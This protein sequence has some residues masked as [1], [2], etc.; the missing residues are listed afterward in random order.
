MNRPSANTNP[1]RPRLMVLL[2]LPCLLATGLV[3]PVPA[4][5]ATDRVTAAQVVVDWNRIAINALEVAQTPAPPAMRIGAIVQASVFDA[6][7]GVTH[8]FEP[9]HVTASAPPSTSVAASAAGAAHEALVLLL[10]AQQP[11]LDAA[12]AHTISQLGGEHHGGA[13]LARGLAWGAAVADQ[14]VSWRATDGISAV[15]PPYLPSP[16]PGRW[17]PAPP[18]FGT[19]AFRQFAIMTPF[20]MASPAQFLPPPPPALT[21]RRYA[22]DFAEVER[23]GQDTSTTRSAFDTVT[24]QFWQSDVGPVAFWDRVADDLI[25]RSHLSVTSAAR[26]LALANVA[27]ADGVISIW[28]AKNYYDTWR[29]LTAIRAADTDGN[30]ATLADPTWN[31]LLATP[32][33]QEYPA[34]HPGVSTAGAQLLRAMFG[35]H[36]SFTLTSPNMPGVQRHFDSFQSAEAQ[37][38]NARVF[39]GIHFRFSGQTAVTMGKAVAHLVITTQMLPTHSHEN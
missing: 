4:A 8:R 11:T 29:P 13:R 3:L 20:A 15:P 12:L 5:T 23:L 21:S 26:V 28:N 35:E 33:F 34:G 39:G 16:D 7:N 30:P 6:V 36:T 37:V 17:Q 22:R 27:M 10:P 9:Y 38:V 2:A 25:N 14:I 19:P 1:A 32:P 31:P 24:A 18:L